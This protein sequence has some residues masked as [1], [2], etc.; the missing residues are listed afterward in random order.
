MVESQT[1]QLAR[2]YYG[3]LVAGGNRISATPGVI[4]RTA[5]I[6]PAQVTECLHLA[7]LA[8]PSPQE[9]NPDMPG[10]LALFRG[11]TI[12]FILAKA[13]YTEAGIPQVLYLL[14]PVA[15][16]RAMGGHVLALRSLALM[17]MP[18]FASVKTN[19]QPYEMRELA[20]PSAEIQTDT[21]LDLLVYCHDSIKHVEG[22]LAALVTGWPLAIV[23]SP[24]SLDLRLRFL[25]GLLCLLP[26]PARVGITFATH[27]A[28]PASSQAQVKFTSQRIVPPQHLVYDWGK[29][30]M[31][32]P[33]PEHSYS[34]YMVAQ[35]RLDPSLVIEQTARLSRTAVWRAMHRENLGRALAWVSR[36]AALDQTVQQ[37]LPADREAV[38]SILREDPTLSDD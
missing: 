28:D 18:P 9:T 7:K 32:T 34:H 35:L 16:L 30:E 15:P 14:M 12:D 13:Q 20:S 5:D 19:L 37:G 8:P 36:R 10:S 38:A 22:L 21:L 17:E 24:A 3:H 6:T 26:L 25:Q 23:N 29:G 33:P 11:E 4:A 2:L 1:F 27:V 31:I